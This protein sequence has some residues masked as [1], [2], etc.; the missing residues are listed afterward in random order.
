MLPVNSRFIK[1]LDKK[2]IDNLIEDHEY[3]F[4]FE[5]GSLIGGFGSSV[6]QYIHK[7][8]NLLRFSIKVLKIPLLNMEQELNCLK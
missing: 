7:K 1:P 8:I 2:M 3:I 6:L 4:T 5:E